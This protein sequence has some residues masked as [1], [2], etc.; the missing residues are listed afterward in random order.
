MHQ[1]LHA[2]HD[3]MFALSPIIIKALIIHDSDKALG[4]D[5]AI[6]APVAMT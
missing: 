6:P 2:G 1:S 3:R 5:L 4:F